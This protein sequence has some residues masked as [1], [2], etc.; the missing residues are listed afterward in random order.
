MRKEEKMSTV[1][2][3][4]PITKADIRIQVGDVYYH[5]SVGSR[6]GTYKDMGGLGCERP[7][8]E[9]WDRNRRIA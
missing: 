1:R 6:Y 9:L 4:I 7:R 8:R 2:R 5:I 3:S